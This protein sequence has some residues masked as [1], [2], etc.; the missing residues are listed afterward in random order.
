[1]KKNQIVNWVS[2]GLAFLGVV[3]KQLHWPFCNIIILLALIS[4]IISI[5]SSF[6]ANKLNGLGAFLNYVITGILLTLVVGVGFDILHWPFASILRML[7]QIFIF[8]LL[9]IL[10][11]ANKENK[12]SSSYW[13]SFLTFVMLVY[14]LMHIRIEQLTHKLW[15][16]DMEIER[17]EDE[18]S[19]QRQILE[20]KEGQ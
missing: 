10:L 13:L 15:D 16:N 11:V 2:F 17:I 20:M 9:L 3:F 8:I 6:K 7:G 19:Q 4:L 12:V 5:F 14:L 1:M 18:M